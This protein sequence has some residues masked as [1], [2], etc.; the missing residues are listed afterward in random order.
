MSNTPT[1]PIRCWDHQLPDDKR[2]HDYND[3]KLPCDTCGKQTYAHFNAE[4]RVWP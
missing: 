1:N 2:C 4:G 3:A